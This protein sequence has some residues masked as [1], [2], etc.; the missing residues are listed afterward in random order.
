M[1][2][3]FGG[4][5][6]PLPYFRDPSQLLVSPFTG[7]PFHQNLQKKSAAGVPLIGYLAFWKLGRIPI[8]FR[9]AAVRLQEGL[10]P[11][12][13]GLLGSRMP[14]PETKSL[15]FARHMLGPMYVN[16]SDEFA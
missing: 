2:W 7:H 1:D 3:N 9:E 10:Y 8:Y 11:V 15:K 6:F 12:H 14:L 16:L 5:R 4:K 13:Q